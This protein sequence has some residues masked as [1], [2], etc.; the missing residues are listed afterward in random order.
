MNSFEDDLYISNDREHADDMFVYVAYKPKS[1]ERTSAFPPSST[2]YVI[3]GTH[4]NDLDHFICLI[5]L[6]YFD[7]TYSNGRLCVLSSKMIL[8]N[9]YIDGFISKDY[10]MKK[11]YKECMDYTIDNN[12]KS[13]Y[14]VPIDL[15]R[16][17]DCMGL[18]QQL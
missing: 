3:I 11:A 4:D 12:K 1:M 16:I 8:K 7:G 5:F 9:L 10:V 15:D 14:G 6:K 13:W 2:R 18:L 17:E